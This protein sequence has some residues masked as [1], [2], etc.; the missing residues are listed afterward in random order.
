MSKN[1]LLLSLFLNFFIK[2][3]NFEDVQYAIKN[4]RNFLYRCLPEHYVNE[5]VF[6]LIKKTTQR[7]DIVEKTGTLPIHFIAQFALEMGFLSDE[8]ELTFENTRSDEALLHQSLQL[9]I[10]TPI[11]SEVISSLN[12]DQR[13]SLLEELIAFCSSH[14]DTSIRLNSLEMFHEIFD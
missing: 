5:E 10:S 12:R 14:L 8:Y 9:F 1:L 11:E 13:K 4:K 6:E 3:V 2:K 7:L